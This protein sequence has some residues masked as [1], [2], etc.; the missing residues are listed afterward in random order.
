M[1]TKLK[2]NK[3]VGKKILALLLSVLTVFTCITPVMSVLADSSIKDVWS[4]SG[5]AHHRLEIDGK[6]AF[7]INYG[8][9]SNG[10][11]E[12]NAVQIVVQVFCNALKRPK[13]NNFSAQKNIL[14][15]TSPPTKNNPKLVII[16]NSF[17]FS[18]YID[19]RRG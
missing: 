14:K 7:C 8:K 3:K 5:M 15:R 4:S 9:A 10:K 2:F 18:V 13:I 1:T 11:F 16:G 6:D 19:T 12:T 17:G